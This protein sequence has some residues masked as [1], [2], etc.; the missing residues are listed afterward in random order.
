MIIKDYIGKASPFKLTAIDTPNSSNVKK[1]FKS[2]YCEY[3]LKYLTS[4]K[5]SLLDLIKRDD[6]FAGKSFDF[7][8]IITGNRDE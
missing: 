1:F 8:I 3:R 4:R 7:P 5:S 6:K 2:I